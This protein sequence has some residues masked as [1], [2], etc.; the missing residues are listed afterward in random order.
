MIT[1]NV[2]E[3]TFRINCKG[4]VGTCFVITV[5]NK[6]YLITARHIAEEIAEVDIVSIYHDSEW[7]NIPVSLIGHT[8]KSVD[9]SVLIADL[10]F[11][12][13]NPLPASGHGLAY[14]Q[15]VYFLG[16]PNVVDIDQASSLGMEI[17]RNF[18]M[19]IVK[20]A[21]H[22]GLGNNKHFF[23]DGYG[24]P[25]FSGGPLVFKPSDSQDYQV[26]G[27]IINYKSEI[28]PV[29]ETKLQAENNGGGI[30]PI[31]Y[32]KGNSGT[33][34]VSWI[35]HAIDLIQGKTL[36]DLQHALSLNRNNKA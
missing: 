15:D 12:S 1:T 2:F 18:P 4:R 24:N 17:N 35:Q 11:S 7:V 27:V 16:F 36:S 10:Y 32:F 6:K 20:H 21:I 30:K 19:P 33:I 26:A 31:G 22:S 29:Y 9:I 8:S 13:N 5:D 25:G 28:I 3:R 23:I 14:G 34:T